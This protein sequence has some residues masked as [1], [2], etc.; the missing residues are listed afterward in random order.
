MRNNCV[1]DGF[2][3]LLFTSLGA[4]ILCFPVAMLHLFTYL[5]R[6]RKHKAFRKTFDWLQEFWI[7]CYDC[8]SDWG[9]HVDSLF[10]IDNHKF[11]NTSSYFWI[12]FYKFQFW[13]TRWRSRSQTW[14][15]QRQTIY[16]GEAWQMCKQDRQKQNTKNKAHHPQPFQR[17]RITLPLPDW[18]WQIYKQ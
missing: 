2:L 14:E 7:P 5:K 6:R 8:V 4:C 9:Q 18:I 11:E 3:L 17:W 13:E 1:I 10:I 16:A 12:C 15:S